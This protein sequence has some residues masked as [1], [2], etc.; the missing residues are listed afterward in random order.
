VD[1][2]VLDVNEKNKSAVA[3]IEATRSKHLAQVTAETDKIRI[4]SQAQAEAQ[5][6]NIKAKAR[7][8]VNMTLAEAELTIEQA[9]AESTKLIAIAEGK[10]SANFARKRAFELAKRQ[11]AVHHDL[12]HNPS[13]FI[14]GTGAEK[15]NLLADMLVSQGN[16]GVMMNVGDLG[17][18][19]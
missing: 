5:V 1:T 15:G 6:Q 14:G 18:S 16:R 19:K 17:Q 12:A 8:T 4:D 2:Q 7:K 11:L 3:E 13:V 9:K 10:A